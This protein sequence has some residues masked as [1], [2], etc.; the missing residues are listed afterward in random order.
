MQ[1]LEAEIRRLE[2]EYNMF[3]AGRLPRLPWEARAKVE[4]M[5]KQ[6]DRSPMQNTADR[7]R[8]NTLQARFSSFCDL[9]EKQLRA[10]EEGR[11]VGGRRPGGSS[12]SMPVAE[13]KR[14][15][16]SGVLHE[17]RIRDP[18]AE[19]ERIKEL[20]HQLTEAR[21]KTG[22]PTV[23]FHR[24]AEAVRAQ[25]TKLGGGDSDVVFRVELK[26]GKATLAVKSAKG[27]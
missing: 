14:E 20:Y 26:E 24:F 1:Q 6:F 10:R 9:W 3:F 19:T 17:S 23:P 22:E 7:F 27:E 12:G 5:V 18:L 11:S 25:V 13:T 4:T 8:F 21:T 16:S 15:R 2:A